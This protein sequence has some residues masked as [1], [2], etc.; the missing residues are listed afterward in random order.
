MKKATETPWQMDGLGVVTGGPHGLTTVCTVPLLA[1]ERSAERGDAAYQQL[2]GQCLEE[3]KAN[4][5][6]IEAA[7]DLLRGCLAALA[8]WDSPYE[9][10]RTE[11]IKIIRE[12][13]WRASL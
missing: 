9:T 2:S 7:P 3:A 11:A 8:Y 10:N 13:V 12:A 6:L 4:G 5:K 1:W